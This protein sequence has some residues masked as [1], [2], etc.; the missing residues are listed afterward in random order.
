MNVLR[1]NEATL[2]ETDVQI[3]LVSEMM[4]PGLETFSV[5]NLREAQEGDYWYEAIKKYIMKNELPLSKKLAQRILLEQQNYI[6]INNILYH[7][8]VRKGK[9]TEPVE[10]ICIT[11]NFKELVWKAM[12]TVPPAGHL[13]ITKT[14]AKMRNRYFWPNM[15]AETTDYV[16]QCEICAQANKGHQAK[17][18]LQPLPV[19][20]GPLERIHID[21][22]SIAV[23]SQGAKYI[24]VIIC[25]FSKYII[26]RPLKRKTSR[27]VAKA[28]FQHYILIFGL[29]DLAYLT[30]T[31]DNGGEFIGS[32]NKTQQHMLGI[33]GSFI[34]PYS[35][36]SNGL[37]EKANRTLLAILRRYAMKES[38]K[39]ARY[40][41]YAVMTINSACS[42]A[43][44]YSPFEL[45]HGVTMREAID[46]QI[47][48][49]ATFTTK[50]QQE[51]HIYWSVQLQ[52]IRSLARNML[53]KAQSTQKIN[54]D[55]SAKPT[56]CKLGDT[57][58]LK[59][60]ALGLTEDPKLRPMY[61]GPYIIL[62][63]F[64]PTNVI[65]SDGE[66]KQ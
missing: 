35:P 1:S 56:E 18:P 31:Q 57:V 61:S 51:A 19:P 39:W 30:V 65:L 52:K 15:S 21:I 43:T 27:C 46:L 41:P 23:P 55:R 37:V 22:L 13:G 58:Y 3:I 36:S 20:T 25:A 24:L 34:T 11:D 49:P 28:F 60:L 53:F 5:E 42:E 9:N 40:L 47:D 59:R 6:V 10:Q 14:Y 17:V 12:H 48:K 2:N 50:E 4:L 45:L 33:K 62:R 66:D 38:Q 44:G 54:Y 64:S 26:A 8:W 16:Q 32:F 7:V 63:F 29:P